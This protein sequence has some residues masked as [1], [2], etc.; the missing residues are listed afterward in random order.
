MAVHFQLHI[1]TSSAIIFIYVSRYSV[2]ALTRIIVTIIRLHVTECKLQHDNYAHTKLAFFVY[3][4]TWL[5]GNGDD[6][7]VL[8]GRA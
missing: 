1:F 2:N 4:F 7:D 3:L 6:S 5:H 8:Q